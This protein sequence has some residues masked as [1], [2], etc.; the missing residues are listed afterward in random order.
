MPSVTKLTCGLHSP[1]VG[2]SWVSTKMGA[3]MGWPS[4]QPRAMSKVRRPLMP[5]PQSVC[6]AFTTGRLASGGHRYACTRLDSGPAPIQVNS[7]SPPRPSGNSMPSSG[8]AM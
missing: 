7:R 1:S 4:F 5:A 8:P 3:S 6:H 2:A